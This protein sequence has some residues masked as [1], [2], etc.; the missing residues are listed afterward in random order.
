MAGHR[1]AVEKVVRLFEDEDGEPQD[2]LS[3]D[4]EELEGDFVDES[5]KQRLFSQARVDEDEYERVQSGTTSLSRQ[6]CMQHKKVHPNFYVTP[7][8]IAAFMGV[9]IA[10]GIVNLPSGCEKLQ[11][12]P[13]VQSVR[14]S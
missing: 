1:L 7:A 11:K 3:H 6:I 5:G 2:D 14:M 8:E 9:N 10:M 12:L 4:R 13:K